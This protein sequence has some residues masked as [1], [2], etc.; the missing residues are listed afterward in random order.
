MRRPGRTHEVRVGE[1]TLI[2]HVHGRGPLCVV[3]PGGPGPHGEYLRIP[4]AERELTMAYLEPAGSGWS[5]TLGTDVEHLHTVI[6][7]LGGD[8]VFVLG[9]GHGGLVA[10][11]YAM[12]HPGRPAGLILYGTTPVAVRAVNG[13]PVGTARNRP[14]RTPT[15]ILAGAH[16]DVAPPDAAGELHAGITG[17]RLAV[18][19]RS[20]HLA[21]VEEAE[22][23]AHLLIEFTR[24]ISGPYR[25]A[26]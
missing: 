14:I 9:H 5:G 21:H 25:A 18:F 16:D 6:E 13:R 8:P 15:L 10:Q 17:S 19:E 24:R 3:H 12:T 11:S 2:C 4:L 1:L 7:R 26:G 20:G 23:F 22:R